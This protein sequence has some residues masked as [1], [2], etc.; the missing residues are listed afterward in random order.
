MPVICNPNDLPAVEADFCNPDINFGQIDRIFFNNEGNPML[1]W[2]DVMEWNTRLDNTTL[3]DA[4]KI[5]WLHVIGDKPAPEKTTL[6]FSQGRQ[7]NTEKTHTV[8]VI[9]DETGPLNYA[10][11]QWLEDNASQN[12]RMWYS[13]GKY[14]YGGNE[15]ISVKLELDDIIPQS[16][17]ELNTFNGTATWKGGHPARIVN[18]I[19]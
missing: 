9:V 2:T 11:V 4:T 14:L 16:D 12:V 15:G 7:I 19:A 6:D 13:A 8:N 3:A 10:L 18:P 1:D 5:R 17:E